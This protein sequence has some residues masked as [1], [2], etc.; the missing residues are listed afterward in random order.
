MRKL[1]TFLVLFV[2]TLAANAQLSVDPAFNPSDKGGGKHAGVF[3]GESGVGRA[4]LLQD[5]KILVGGFYRI[6][7]NKISPGLSLLNADGS[8]NT[9]FQ[10]PD[11]ND[12]LEDGITA[13]ALQPDGKILL[14]GYMSV[15]HGKKVNHLIRINPNGSLDNS[16]RTGL[17]FN[18]Y[19]EVPSSI[20]ALPDGK[21]II[22]GNFTSY[23]GVAVNGLIRLKANGNLDTTFNFQTSPTASIRK[24]IAESDGKLIV[25]GRF[26]IQSNTSYQNLVRLNKNGSLDESFN[27]GKKLTI[28][29][30]FAFEVQP[31]KKIIFTCNNLVYRIKKD[32]SQ[33]T[34]FVNGLIMNDF[35]YDKLGRLSDIKIQKDGKILLAGHITTYNN[36]PQKSILRLNINGSIDKS[37]KT[38]IGF[39]GSSMGGSPDNFIKSITLFNN[40]KIFIA[41]DF[42]FYR[43]IWQGTMAVLNTDGSIDNIFNANNGN[44][45][46]ASV[47]KIVVQPDNKILIAG[48]FRAYN[49]VNRNKIAR[50]NANGTLDRTFN[51]GTGPDSCNFINTM[52]LQKDGKILVGGNFRY[53]NKVLKSF[54][55]RLN[56]D[57]SIDNSFN[58][59]TFS[60]K[61]GDISDGVRTIALQADGKILIGF[62]LIRNYVTNE[63]KRNVLLR[64]N[65]DGSADKSFNADQINNSDDPQVNSIQIQNNGKILVGGDFDIYINGS[66]KSNLV[67]LN[68]NGTLD[69]TF[70]ISGNGPNYRIY[71]VNIEKGGKIII[72][73]RFNYYN[74]INISYL[75]RL[76]TNGSLDTSYKPS[77]PDN[78]VVFPRS[79][80][81]SNNKVILSYC[82]NATDVFGRV[83]RYNTDGSLDNEFG[84]NNKADHMINDMALQNK[85][86]L[87]GGFIESFNGMQ[88]NRIT[89]I[90]TPESLNKVA[91]F[92][93]TTDSLKVQ[94]TKQSENISIGVY[95]NPAHDVLHIK[96][97]ISGS[98]NFFSIINSKGEVVNNL[99]ISENG[100]GINIS[101]LQPGVYHIKITSGLNSYTFKFVKL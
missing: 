39:G 45:A 56:N 21:I 8:V 46:D 20:V 17:G 87:L 44:G 57:G 101:N 80:I 42:L 96:N 90:N 65:V 83:I 34:A 59:N 30:V 97:L 9:A 67:R 74:N 10:G 41:G 43:G 27:P 84:I 15:Y 63:S 72:T 12:D 48:Y 26:T 98:N 52:V 28:N 11:V 76:N 58:F 82:Y 22:G 66:V 29:E 54:I 50:L 73:G 60:K 35:N 61:Y 92:S 2:C 5:G 51:P 19:E 79:I 3:G 16:F 38:G 6:L 18:S 71:S 69:E 62:E 14:A 55:V 13:M 70:N 64:L 32:G 4:L 36:T 86:L 95:P 91:L 47:N 77:I 85:K 99:R 53:F 93:G 31:D 23:N 81:D 37:F 78:S 75:A 1:F 100:H 7:H 40:G 88:H 94:S 89:R 49:G 25:G 24:I 33:D 68:K